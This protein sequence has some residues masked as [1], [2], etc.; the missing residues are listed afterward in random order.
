[1]KKHKV[2]TDRGA[3]IWRS[4]KDLHL[5]SSRDFAFPC[6]YLGREREGEAGDLQISSG[7]GGNKGRGIAPG[8]PLEIS[9]TRTQNKGLLRS[10]GRATKGERE[11]ERTFEMGLRY[12]VSLKLKTTLTVLEEMH[13]AQDCSPYTCGLGTASIR[14]R[15]N[16]KWHPIK[17]FTLSHAAP[18]IPFPSHLIGEG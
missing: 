18:K 3:G 8:G 9:G 14:M 16:G 6:S 10:M 2:T 7:V 17:H 4:L 11:R 5:G 1:M 13:K 15:M 12:A